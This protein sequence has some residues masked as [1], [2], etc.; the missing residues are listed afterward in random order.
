MKFSQQAYQSVEKIINTIRQ[1][2]FN[3]ELMQGTLAVDKF[4]YYIEQDSLYLNE[5]ARCVA[6]IASKSPIEYTNIFLTYAKDVL[7]T[8]QELVHQYF[9]KALNLK[10]T[11]M[12]SLA[13][14]SY[15]SYLL[16]ICSNEPFEVAIAV[17]LPCFWVYYDV[18]VFIT[19]Q[20]NNKDNPYARWIENYNN[21]EFADATMEMINICD[22]FAASTSKIVYQKMLDVFYKATC[23][24][25]HF[26]NDSYYQ[27]VFDAM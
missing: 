7:F 9:I 1:H 21:K 13:T 2:P 18:G 19:K 24:E 20:A 17:I 4:A 5:F 3:R 25:W 14:L 15:T 23:L 8:E 16:S 12:L 11:N 6:I 10:R 27:T 26:C 22:K